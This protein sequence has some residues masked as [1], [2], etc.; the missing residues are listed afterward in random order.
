MPV[1]RLILMLG[2]LFMTLPVFAQADDLRDLLDDYV[3]ADD[4]AVVVLVS[5]D[6]GEQVILSRGLA[7]LENATP[8]TETD[9]FRIGSTTKTFVA[10]IVLQLAEEGALSLDNTIAQYLPDTL[11]D[12]I[13]NSD[14]ITIRQLLNMTSGVFDYTESDAF[15]DAVQADPTYPWTAAETLDF[16][17]DEAPY[18]APGSDWYYSNSN[19]N[20]LQMIIESV[21]GDPLR[22]V[23]QDRIFGPLGMRDSFLEDPA[24]IGTGIIRGYG[25]DDNDDLV[26]MTGINDGIGLGDGGIIST[27]ADLDLFARALFEGDLLSAESYTAMT[28]FTPDGDDGY[29]GLGLGMDETEYGDIIGHDGATSGFQSSLGYHPDS[30]VVVIALTNN[31]DTDILEDLLVDIWEVVLVG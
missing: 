28:D 9:Q 8:V 27:A 20:L 11:R 17:V 3:G 23:L 2:L 18:F 5:T 24:N 25:Y 6:D 15:D 30:G 19:Y 12:G 29:Y 10:T 4:P 14:Q 26:D 31:F 7:D 22:E 16:V 13:A 1:H 21:T